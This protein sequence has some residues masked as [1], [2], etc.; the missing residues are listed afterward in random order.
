MYDWRKM[1]QEE[2]DEV[3]AV[4]RQRRFPKHSP[5]HFD[6]GQHVMNTCESLGKP[7]NG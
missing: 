2:R 5:P 4:R 6:L 3:S 7:T 1:T